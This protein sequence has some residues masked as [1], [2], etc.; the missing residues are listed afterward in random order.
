MAEEKEV[1]GQEI[2]IEDKEKD[3]EL[4]IED[5]TPEQDR[6]RQ[7]LPKEM[8]Q[9]LEEDELEEYSEKVKTRLKQM[10]KVWHDERR[11]KESALR[12]QQE[13]VNLAQNLVEE[14]KKLK[15]RLT[16]GE[17]VINYRRLPA[18]PSWRCKWQSGHIKRLMTRA[19]RT[20]L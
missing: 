20:K 6:N 5:D 7:P 17:K 10:K 13:A 15:S 4:E 8:V 3:F 14:N 11:E 18:Q 12:E 19:I 1:Q 9:E 2:D 16:E